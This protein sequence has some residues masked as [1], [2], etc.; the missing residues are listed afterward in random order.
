V[1]EVP[2]LEPREALRVSAGGSA[3]GDGNPKTFHE[4]VREP[5][6]AA[7]VS[8]EADSSGLT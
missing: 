6:L 7:L 5:R 1:A 4:A 3:L 8:S 2:V